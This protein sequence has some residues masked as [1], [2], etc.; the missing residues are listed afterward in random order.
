METKIKFK[1]GFGETIYRAPILRFTDE[2]KH[3]IIQDYL[4]SGLT[5][6]DIWEKYTGR[7]EEHGRILKWM[8]ALGYNNSVPKRITNF[9]SKHPVMKKK[10]STTDQ[11]SFEV[12]QL[13][14][15]IEELEKQISDSEMKA[16]AFS[17]MV[18]LAE[19][20]FNIS[21]RKKYNTKPSKQ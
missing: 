15:R 17:T 13:K 10:A 9:V 21:I 5:K 6:R 3:E 11:D 2:Q 18:D 12:Q 7:Q 19:K 16:T 1:S 20:E 8:R 4:N 14:K